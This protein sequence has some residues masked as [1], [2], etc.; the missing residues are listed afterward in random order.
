MGCFAVVKSIF[1]IWNCIEKELEDEKQKSS[2]LLTF[3]V[4]VGKEEG[5]F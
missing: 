1:H 3:V 2:I 4:R 5:E